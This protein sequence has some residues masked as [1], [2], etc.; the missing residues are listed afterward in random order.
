MPTDHRAE[1][2]N[3]KRFDQLIAYLRD[4][5]GW[6]I[7]RDSFE[8]VDDL[9]YDFT[10]DE[11]GIDPEDRRQDPGDQAP[12]PALAE[13]ALGHLLR[14]VRAEEASRRRAAPHPEPGG[15]QEARLRQQ[16]RAR[17]L[18]RGRPA[19][20]LQLRR[21]R[22]APDQLR[23]LLAGRRTATTCRPSRCSAGTTSTPRCTSTPSPRS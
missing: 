4:E 17:R 20:H 6:P 22:R 14:Q 9:F 3:I 23:P 7:A 10:A 1:L 13:A 5:M 12:A 8:D 11:L 15:A 18:G 19:L 21:G 16:R 2:A